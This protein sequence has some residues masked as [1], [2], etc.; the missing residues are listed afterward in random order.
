MHSFCPIKTKKLKKHNL[1]PLSQSKIQIIT[2]EET[3]EGAGEK[4]G[5]GVIRSNNAT[6][7]TPNVPTLSVTEEDIPGCKYPHGSV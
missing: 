4:E 1:G 3:G 2:D 5:G 6:G 7:W